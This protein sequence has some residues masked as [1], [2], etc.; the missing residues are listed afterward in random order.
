MAIESR[1]VIAAAPNGTDRIML[2]SEA[3]CE[4]AAIDL[5]E[6]LKPD[7]RGSWTNYFKGVLAGFLKDGIR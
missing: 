4:T 7:A 6:R 2:H 1:T 3:F 5:T